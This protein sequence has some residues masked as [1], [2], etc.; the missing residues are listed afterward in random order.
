MTVLNNFCYLEKSS[1]KVGW[2]YFLLRYEL[3]IFLI[4]SLM[5]VVYCLAKKKPTIHVNDVNEF[6][7]LLKTNRATPSWK[8]VHFKV[9]VLCV[10]WFQ[11]CQL[12]KFRRLNIFGNT[13][14][15]SGQNLYNARTL[16]HTPLQHLQKFNH[17]HLAIHPSTMATHCK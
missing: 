6:C 17:L 5:Y 12:V 14:L 9:S 3:G 1:K 11:S 10:S 7:G 13:V 8:S 4:E 16:T 15:P 2:L